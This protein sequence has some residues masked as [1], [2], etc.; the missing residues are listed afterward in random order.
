MKHDRTYELQ[1]TPKERREQ[2]YGATLTFENAEGV[3]LTI[4]RRHHSVLEAV[5]QACD[6]AIEEDSTYRVVCLSTPHTIYSDMQGWVS[7]R[8]PSPEQHTVTKAGRK[9]ML[10]PRI[11]A[12]GR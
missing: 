1:L 3:T 7:G 4:A 5:R 12:R 10:H 8:R 9:A 11:A 6:L 2:Q